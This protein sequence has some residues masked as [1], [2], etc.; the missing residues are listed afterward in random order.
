MKYTTKVKEAQFVGGVKIDP[1]GG[2]FSEGDV[3]AIVADA[4]GRDLIKKG[5]LSIEG[6]KPEDLDKNDKQK[7]TGEAKQQTRPIKTETSAVP[8]PST[9]PQNSGAAKQGG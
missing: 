4:Y 1:K 7:K 6:V 3:K 9:A 8:Q 2:D 5:Y